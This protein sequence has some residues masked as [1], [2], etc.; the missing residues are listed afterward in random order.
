M[1][2]RYFAAAIV[3]AVAVS[4]VVAKERPSKNE[5]TLAQ[6]RIQMS[7]KIPV[8]YCPG[9]MIFKPNG[10][11]P[12]CSAA[13]VPELRYSFTAAAAAQA[14]KSV[15]VSWRQEGDR[16][17]PDGA[18]RAE[19][20]LIDQVS[21]AKAQASG[22]LGDSPAGCIAFLADRFLVTTAPDTPFYDWRDM[23]SFD[24]E[25]ARRKI[26]KF[27]LVLPHTDI[28]S[29]VEEFGWRDGSPRYD[30]VAVHAFVVDSIIRS[31]EISGRYPILSDNPNDYKDSGLSQ[32]LQT[33][34]PQCIGLEEQEFYQ[35]YWKNLVKGQ[36]YSENNGKWRA[37]SS[38]VSKNY[39]AS[40]DGALCGLRVSSTSVTGQTI[41][42]E[43]RTLRGS[44]KALT[45]RLPPP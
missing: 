17:I 21:V 37:S 32:F 3:F 34:F 26:L 19:K 8:E 22:C 15:I 23:A 12:Y 4:P 13:S 11:F 20:E 44:T 5:R 35:M 7:S 1:R 42:D 9:V 18:G 45:F 28:A 24:P 2:L 16:T 33:F 38:G 39:I 25:Q 31:I 27:Q 40:S 41:S 10:F 6:A 29:H 36:R 43:G 14:L 30:V